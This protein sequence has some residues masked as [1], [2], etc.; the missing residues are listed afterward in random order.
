M[1]RF[2]LAVFFL[3]LNI[4]LHAQSPHI[5]VNDDDKQ[6]VLE[7][8]Q[9]Q[10]WAASIFEEMEKEVSVY[11]DRHQTDP[12]WIL[13]RYL[14]NRVPGK[15]YKRVYS[16]D[17]G[18]N[19]VKWEGDAPVPTVRI[20]TYLRSPITE[21]GTSYRKPTIE[22]LVPNDTSR[23][24]FLF[25]PENNQKEWVDPQAYIT[26][27]NG[28]INNLALDAAILYWLKGEEKYARFAA[29]ILD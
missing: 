17:S 3:L 12:Q 24:M 4:Q 7:K 29:D 10:K 23:V 11:A 8:V 1:N 14:M 18:Q 27:I 13:S 21:K 20:N 28:E 2:L 19:L 25:N 16:D 22:E 5:L 26:S 6:A 9:Q 15:R